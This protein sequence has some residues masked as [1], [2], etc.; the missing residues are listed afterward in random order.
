MYKLRIYVLNYCNN[1]DSIT[2]SKLCGEEVQRNLLQSHENL[3]I[4]SINVKNGQK[5]ISSVIRELLTFEQ[6]VIKINLCI[7]QKGSEPRVFGMLMDSCS[8][9]L[10]ANVYEPENLHPSK[11]QEFL[12]PIFERFNSLLNAN[13]VPLLKQFET[14]IETT[15]ISSASTVMPEL[16]SR[17][18]KGEHINTVKKLKAK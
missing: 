1:P 8:N 4:L 18:I 7:L 16:V 12:S 10:H 13:K 17:S 2:L 9:N 5:D 14:C 3:Q 6:N 11:L 15:D